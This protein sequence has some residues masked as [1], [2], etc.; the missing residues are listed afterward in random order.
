MKRLHPNLVQAAASVALAVSFAGGCKSQQGSASI[1]PF[2][3]PNR[4]PPPAT[5]SLMPGQAQPYYQGDPL[6]VMQTNAAPAAAATSV[7]TAEP[8]MPSAE[9]NL[10]WTSPR[11]DSAA[12]VAAAA[13]FSAPPHVQPQPVSAPIA[14]A[15]PTAIAANEPSIAI[16]DDGNS[17][18]FAPGQLAPP[19]NDP[20]P[21]VPNVPTAVAS[22]Q[23]SVQQVLAATPPPAQYDVA[24]A[25]YVTPS[26]PATST[27]ATSPW[28][29]PQITSPAVS[30]P[31]TNIAQA[32][33]P[34]PFQAP[35]L[36]PPTVA[37]VVPPPVVATN[38]MGVRLRAVPSPIDVNAP[39]V[40]RVRIPGYG[41][42]TPMLSSNDGFRPRTSMR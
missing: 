31:A 32:F 40:P 22:S 33:V 21:F 24:Q 13:P 6:P 29:S 27:V 28:R 3:A 15:P 5:R 12:M 4:V 36:A 10:P 17:L 11:G 34:Q 8:E 38:T 23:T 37:P 16:P 2:L 42:E 35:P 14:S 26:I 7:A 39:P 1:N 9:R 19:V 25:S 20:R 30:P 18:R 41:Y